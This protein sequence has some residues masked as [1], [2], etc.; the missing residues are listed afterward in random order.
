MVSISRDR[1]QSSIDLAAHVFTRLNVLT[2]LGMKTV[3]SIEGEF[4]I[5]TA[6][7]L[8]TAT[9]RIRRRECCVH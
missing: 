9:E 5:L 2:F 8:Q 7:V 6:S 3:D 4:V 1:G